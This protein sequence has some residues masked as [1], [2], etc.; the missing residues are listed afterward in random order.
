MSEPTQ[1]AD[2]VPVKP[3]H[4]SA[5]SMKRTGEVLIE[6]SKALRPLTEESRIRVLRAVSELHGFRQPR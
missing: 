5:D 1:T 3:D 6:I 4:D 2:V